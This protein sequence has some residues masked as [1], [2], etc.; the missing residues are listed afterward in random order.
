M[1]RALTAMGGCAK[2]V[3]EFFERREE[4]EEEEED[5]LLLEGF[6]LDE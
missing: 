2:M 3:M 5:T 6:V 4:E 1:N